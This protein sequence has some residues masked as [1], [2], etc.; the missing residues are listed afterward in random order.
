[1]ICRALDA[2][3]PASW[4]AGDEI[5]GGNP[6]C[7]P[8]WKGVGPVT[9]SPSAET[10]RSAPAR[11][12]SGPTSWS[13][14]C[15]SGPG[16]SS[17]PASE[18]RGTAST[19]GPWPTSSTAGHHH[20][21]VRRNR[22][23]GELAFYRCYSASQRPLSTLVQVAGHRWTVEE[24]FQSGKGL[25]GLAE[26]QV[27][28]WTSWHRWVTLAMLAHAFLAVV[29]ADED[30]RRP[31][32]DGL[33]PLT[34]NEVQRLFKALIVRLVQIAGVPGGGGRSGAGGRTGGRCCV[35]C[36]GCR[37]RASARRAAYRA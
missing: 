22:R 31:R 24:T 1:M 6:T 21:L 14:S 37:C 36:R 19:T 25:A 11:A 32:P 5:Y 10:T 4:V 28:R 30:A 33:I 2:G 29:R 20:L 3:V 13:R 16:R 34:C 23:T 12:S 7:E 15:R 27:R 9:Y 8:S 18:Q 26:H 35:R 17:P